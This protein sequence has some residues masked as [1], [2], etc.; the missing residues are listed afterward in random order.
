MGMTGEGAGELGGDLS[1]VWMGWRSSVAQAGWP[2]ALPG[3][4]CHLLANPTGGMKPRRQLEKES[5]CG[6]VVSLRPET[7]LCFSGRTRGPIR[8]MLPAGKAEGCY[9]PTCF[10]NPVALAGLQRDVALAKRSPGMPDL[11]LP[12][13]HVHPDADISPPCPTFAHLQR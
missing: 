4:A 7:T 2:G 8:V 3:V 5:S 1:A 11:P 12:G 10:H 9:G 6:L 13:I